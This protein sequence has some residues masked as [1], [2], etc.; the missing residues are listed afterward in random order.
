MRELTVIGQQEKPLG[1][2][3]EAPDRKH[4]GFVGH[5]PDDGGSPL[6][7]VSRGHHPGGLVQEVVDK[8]GADPNRC[9][10]HL[11]EGRLRV[12]PTSQDR[13]YTINGDPPGGDEVLARPAATYAD[14]GQH[15]LEPL[16]LMSVTPVL[17]RSRI[18]GR[19]GHRSALRRRRRGPIRGV[20][21]E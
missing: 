7:I 5:Q 19:P 9:A 8:T 20:P 12:D 11:D 21:I 10:V 17:A 15:L 18:R 14:T 2:S 16:A 6:R 13:H 4:P 1:V 3:V